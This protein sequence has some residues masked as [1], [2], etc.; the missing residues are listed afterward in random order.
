MP[1]AA[2]VVLAAAG[3]TAVDSSMAAAGAG[4]LVAGAGAARAGAG[5]TTRGN[6]DVWS[7]VSLEGP[8]AV[9]VAAGAVAVAGA[10]AGANAAVAAAAG[11]GGAVPGVGRPRSAV[12][13]GRWTVEIWMA[14]RSNGRCLRILCWVDR[15]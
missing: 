3:R 7:I 11:A 12:S 13:A 4:R 1:D 6:S 5:Y 9:A 10:D 8:V 2:D 14:Q 15:Q